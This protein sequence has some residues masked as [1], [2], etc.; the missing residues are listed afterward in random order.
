MEATLQEIITRAKQRGILFC[1]DWDSVAHPCLERESMSTFQKVNQM[2][3]EGDQGVIQRV[4]QMVMNKIA[5]KQLA[6]LQTNDAPSS[7]EH[8]QAP[9]PASNSYSFSFNFKGQQK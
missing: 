8:Q 9:Q 5:N 6:L 7:T 4:E 1:R 2:I 3:K